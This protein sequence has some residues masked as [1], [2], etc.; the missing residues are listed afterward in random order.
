MVTGFAPEVRRRVGRNSVGMDFVTTTIDQR[1]LCAGT[2]GWNRQR[3]RR[4]A[5]ER[6]DAT[7]SGNAVN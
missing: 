6:R 7:P 5:C 3:H 1:S 4:R 2:M